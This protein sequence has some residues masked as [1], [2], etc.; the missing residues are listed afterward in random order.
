[1]RLTAPGRLIGRLLP[2]IARS[3]NDRLDLPPLRFRLLGKDPLQPLRR[4]LF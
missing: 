3:L 4:R 2:P 1:M